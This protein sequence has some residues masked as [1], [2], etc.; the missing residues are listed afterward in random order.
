[1]ASACERPTVLITGATGFLGG[2]TLA[3]L[4]L[5][6]PEC[7]VLALVRGGDDADSRLRKSLSRFLSPAI[8]DREWA[9]IELLR[10]DLSQAET[11]LDPRLNQVTHVIH[12]A[13]NTSFRSIRSVRETNI[14]GTMALAKRLV[15][16]QK[17][18]RFLHVGTA[19]IC[20]AETTRVVQEA[21]YP[22]TGVRHVTE[23]TASKAECELQLKRLNPDF[24]LIVARPS[25]VVGHTRLGCGPSSSLY[26]YYRA[27]SWLRRLPVGPEVYKDIV[28][29]DYVAMA[30]AHLLFRPTLRHRCYHISAGRRSSVR[31]GE[32]VEEI[33]RLGARA[34]LKPVQVVD[35]QTLVRERHRWQQLLGPGDQERLALLLGVL[36]QFS[37]CGVEFFDNNRLLGERLSAPPPFTAY[38]AQCEHSAAG[39]SVYDQM[40][41][42]L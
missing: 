5:G 13:A 31:W 21:D 22:R 28:P 30:L 42:D 11:W 1:M 7:K 36:F 34:N 27:L 3:E 29:V 15:R 17:L 2:A 39:R 14:A 32:I 33:S 24:P 4:V 25:I 9:R 10:G 40:A 37:R 26:W 41:E 20:G 35:F 8:C 19:Y 23:Y 12:L 38:L 16:T 18:T 6:R